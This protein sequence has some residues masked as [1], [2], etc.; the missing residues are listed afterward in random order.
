VDYQNINDETLLRIIAFSDRS[1]AG[2]AI[3]ALYDRYNRL[4]YSL[5]YHIVKDGGIAEE[6]IQ[7]VFTRVWEKAETYRPEQ[8]K[9]STWISSITR[10]RAIDVLRKQ[11]VRP[12]LKSIT[13]DDVPLSEIPHSD[14]HEGQLESISMREEVSSAISQLSIEQRQALNLAYFHGLTHREI[15]EFLDEPLG[16]V[17]TRIRSGM[18]KLRQIIIDQHSEDNH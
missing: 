16:T 11:S 14:S 7:D 18:K 9:V 10:Y 1:V 4:V 6:I 2:D 15:S 13:W 12:E 3:S 17:K 8:A 5:A